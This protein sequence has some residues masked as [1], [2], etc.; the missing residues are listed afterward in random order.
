L[1]ISTDF[2]VIGTEFMNKSN[3][4]RVKKTCN[5]CKTWIM[6]NLCCVSSSH[7]CLQNFF[8]Q[9]TE[10]RTQSPNFCW[11]EGTTSLYTKIQERNECV[12]GWSTNSEFGYLDCWK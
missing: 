9:S 5:I 11:G 7:V 8:I 6:N 4:K 12:F 3:T 10:H 1:K 2:I